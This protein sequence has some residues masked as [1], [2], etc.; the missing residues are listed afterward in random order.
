MRSLADHLSDTN[1][2]EVGADLAN[3]FH[4]E[5]GVSERLKGLVGTHFAI[6]IAQFFKPRPNREH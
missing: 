4:F 3:T 2:R 6:E 1:A 5:S